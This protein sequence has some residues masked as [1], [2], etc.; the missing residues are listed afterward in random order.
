MTGCAVNCIY[1]GRVSTIL[2]VLADIMTSCQLIVH[3][4]R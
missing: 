4:I 1:I 3:N 2:L